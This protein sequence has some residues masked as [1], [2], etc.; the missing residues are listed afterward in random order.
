M[1]DLQNMTDDYCLTWAVIYLIIILFPIPH[2]LPAASPQMLL[3]PLVYNSDIVSS[4]IPV[5][6]FADRSMGF[7]SSAL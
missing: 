7:S 2:S 6:L 3:P 4:L 1:Q 5:Q